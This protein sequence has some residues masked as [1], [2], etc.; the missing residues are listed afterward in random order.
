MN[1]DQA[2]PLLDGSGFR[3]TTMNDG[4]SRTA[5]PCLDCVEPHVTAEDAERHF[6]DACLASVTEA[7]FG[8]WHGC[9]ICDSPTKGGLGNRANS[10]VF[11]VEPLCADHRTRE[12]LA[13]LHPFAPGM[14]LAH[15]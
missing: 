9:R 2:R 4:Q 6:Y 7:R 11:S 8:E 1:Y 3:W 13:D 12:H 14:Q 5:W 10:K 15:S